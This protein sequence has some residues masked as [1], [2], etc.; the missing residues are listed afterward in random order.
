MLAVDVV[1][2]VVILRGCG[3]RVFGVVSAKC[4]VNR[5]M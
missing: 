5:E 4:V 1:A 3:M 2:H